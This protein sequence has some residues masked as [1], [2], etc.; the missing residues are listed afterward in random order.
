MPLLSSKQTYRGGNPALNPPHV[1]E[2]KHRRSR[3]SGVIV[4]GI[5]AKDSLRRGAEKAPIQRGQGA[6]ALPVKGG[7][8]QNGGEIARPD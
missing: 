3:R 6:D 4:I 8:V 1:R 5:E 2:G 7:R